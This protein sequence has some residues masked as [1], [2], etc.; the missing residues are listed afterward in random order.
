MARVLSRCVGRPYDVA[1][2]YGGEE[3]VLLVEA[4]QDFAAMLERLRREII[5]LEIPHARSS[6]A[7]ILT[8]SGGGLVASITA[9]TDPTMLLECADRLLYRA[10]REGRNR[11]LIETISLPASSS[12]D[13]A[14]L[15][16][17]GGRVAEKPGPDET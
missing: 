10:K 5:A 7:G 14:G 11:I 4:G 17:P 15:E 12:M 13:D 3:F 8:V 16:P 1:A 6:A 9:K 2:R